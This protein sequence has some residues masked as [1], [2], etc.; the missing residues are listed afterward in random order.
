LS[1]TAVLLLAAGSASRMGEPKQLLK[2]KNTTILENAI[3][4]ASQLK[5]EQ[6]VVVLGA[7]YETI[8]SNINKGN[9]S[10]VKN[11][12]WDQG[13]GNSIAFGV[14][15]IQES[16]TE[17]ENILIMLAD[18]PLID[19]NFLNRMVE[20]HII[21]ENQIVCTAYKNKKLGVPAIFNKLFF[22]ELMQL[23]S[24]KGARNILKKY[25]EELI[26]INGGDLIQDIDTMDEYKTIYNKHH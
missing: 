26:Y 14:R 20:Q 2:W 16:F 17:I 9:H 13:L 21:N 5:V 24:D 15:Y 7:H 8:I 1:K 11:K 6:T 22:E 4:V 10:V 12:Y 23:N 3:Q 19:F 18:Q 25:S